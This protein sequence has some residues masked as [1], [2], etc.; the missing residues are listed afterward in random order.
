[1]HCPV[2]NEY[3]GAGEDAETNNVLPQSQ[4]VEAKRAENGSSRYFYVKA[5][6]VVD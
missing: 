3:E 2:G 4:V 5:I 1:M 6:F